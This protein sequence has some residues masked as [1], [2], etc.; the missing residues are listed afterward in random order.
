MKTLK[1]NMIMFTIAALLCSCSSDDNNNPETGDEIEIRPISELAEDPDFIKFME[2]YYFPE[3]EIPDLRVAYETL[4]EFEGQNLF[5]ER[6]EEQLARLAVAF[7]YANAEDMEIYLKELYK[8]QKLLENNYKLSQVDASI[9]NN[10]QRAAYDQLV[11]KKVNFIVE[12]KQYAPKDTR[13]VFNKLLKECQEKD[14]EES[15]NGN[16]DACY[17]VQ[18]VRLGELYDIYG[19]DYWEVPSQCLLAFEDWFDYC[20]KKRFFEYMFYV[21]ISIFDLNCCIVH[22][23]FDVGE[24]FAE[25]SEEYAEDNC[26]VDIPVS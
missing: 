20:T 9:L 3:T 15:L 11:L 12:D 7:G 1:T 10:I 14:R 16:E 13:E 6:N 8:R 25:F 18:K 22:S 19:I 23:C 26:D 24:D 2:L 4:K 21:D 17:S 5:N